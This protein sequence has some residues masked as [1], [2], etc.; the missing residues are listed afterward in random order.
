MN[1]MIKLI[2]AGMVLAAGLTEK[3]NATIVVSSFSV[4]GVAAIAAPSANKNVIKA[5]TLSNDTSTALCVFMKDGTT[6]KLVLC[7]GAQSTK[8]WPEGT[9]TVTAFN[10]T[11][12]NASAFL[13]EDLKISGAFNVTS[14]TP[15]A[16][17]TGGGALIIAYVNK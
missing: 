11:S 17:A 16:N 6:L 3:A 4:A 14:S 15:A 5:V 8:T 10:G 13:G 7:A 9:T 1:K 12:G 2:L